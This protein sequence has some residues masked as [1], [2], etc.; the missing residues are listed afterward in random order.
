[1]KQLLTQLSK[2]ANDHLRDGALPAAEK[3]FQEILALH[4]SN[5]YALV[6]LAQV[7]KRRGDTP[8]AVRFY[9]QC[10]QSSPYN[11]IAMLGLA[12]CYRAS[13][14]LT[15]A[16]AIWEKL[17][18]LH[19]QE[20]SVLTR[21]ADAYRR[22]KRY[23]KARQAYIDALANEHDNIYALIGLGYLCYELHDFP[24]ALSHWSQAY[25]LEATHGDVK[26]LTNLGNCHRKLK[27][28]AAAV[29]YFERA[30][31]LEADN[32][33]ALFGLAD[34]YRGTRELDQSLHYWERILVRDPANKIVLTR[35]G[36]ALRQ[37]GRLQE[38]RANYEAALKIGFDCFAAMGLATVLKAQGHDEEAL[39]HLRGILKI[40]PDNLRVQQLL[41]TCL[42]RAGAGNDPGPP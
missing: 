37:L 14:Q 2:T 29:V 9:Q 11:R 7:A 20:T 5:S 23:D 38:A 19:G 39:P 33:F 34:C 8:T 16:L 26:L 22:T 24:H 36:D 4:S 40:D 30:L 6:G 13:Q 18:E 17:L 41:A 31:V 10:L 28:F 15:K 27:S 1:V 32:F 35:A 3:A 42:Q 12:N 25:T 21:M